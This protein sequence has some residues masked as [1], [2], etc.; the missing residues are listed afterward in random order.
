MQFQLK[1]TAFE[2]ADVLHTLQE[3]GYIK[4]LSMSFNMVDKA[5]NFN[6]EVNEGSATNGL[7]P[8]DHLSMIEIKSS[9]EA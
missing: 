4:H 6:F 3:D 7:I 2:T 5:L 1:L 9:S 8:Y